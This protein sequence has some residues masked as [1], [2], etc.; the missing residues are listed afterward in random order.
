MYR[1]P[2]ALSTFP[3][4]VS[5]ILFLDKPLAGV[6]L[7]VHLCSSSFL[8]RLVCVQCPSSMSPAPAGEVVVK[9]DDFSPVYKPF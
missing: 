9:A 4:S 8:K 7:L 1:N 5:Y 6:H 3:F 2:D